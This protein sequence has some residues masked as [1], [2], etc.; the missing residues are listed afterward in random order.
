MI[1][2]RLSVL[3]MLLLIVATPS[4]AGPLRDLGSTGTVY[5]IAE[6]DL[7]AELRLYAQ[8]HAPSPEK[9]QEERGHYRP[10]DMRKLPKAD[11]NRTF[12]VDMTY[13]LAHDIKDGSGNI[14]YPRGYTI[15]P[16]Q[17][18][19]FVGGIVVID[20]SDPGQVEWFQRSPYFSNQLA[21]LLLSDGYAFELTEKL[22]RPVYYLTDII[23]KRLQLSAVPSIVV[24][25]H[26]ALSV[27]EVKLEK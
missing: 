11:R 8:A 18:F 26:D 15:N 2:R 14:L 3:V 22:N 21:L 27:R 7:L 19:N 9:Q 6:P 25:K 1:A 10:K 13:S 5:A 23:A 17:Y 24:K 16:L 4:F 12:D 20:G